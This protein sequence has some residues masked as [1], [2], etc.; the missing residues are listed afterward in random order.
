MSNTSAEPTISIAMLVY[1]HANYLDQALNSIFTQKISAPFEVVI[2]E[3][4]STDASRDIIL[5]WAQKYPEQITYIF[6]EKNVG[7]YENTREVNARC[8]GKYVAWLEGDDFWLDEHKLQKQFDFLE[9]HPEYIGTAHNVRVVDVNGE[10]LPGHQINYPIRPERDFTLDDFAH[11]EWPGQTASLFY[12]NFV[13]EM[14]DEQ[15]ECYLAYEMNGDVKQIGTMLLYGKMRI[16]P[17]IM[18]AYRFVQIGGSNWNSLN[19]GKNF[20]MVYYEKTVALETLLSKLAQRTIT[21]DNRRYHALAEAVVYV[22]RGGGKDDRRILRAIWRREPH[23][24][25]ALKYCARL[26]ARH[27]RKR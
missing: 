13:Q 8:T 9:A 22:V 14:S 24:A 12:R 1:N 18:S 10:P 15:R 7:M 26:A 25:G 17:E 5:R 16:F 27:I 11:G 4:C 23:K 20:S 6:R 3:D 2:G 21:L 19:Y